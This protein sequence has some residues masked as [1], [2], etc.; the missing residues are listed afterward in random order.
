MGQK[1]RLQILVAD[2]DDATRAMIGATL[3]RNGYDV[4][5]ARDGS[6]ALQS[7]RSES[8][9][10]VVLDLMM[11]VVS[12]WDVLVVRA[13]DA[14]LRRIPVIVAS[15]NR[16]PELLDALKYGVMALLPKPFELDVLHALVS[17]CLVAATDQIAPR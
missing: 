7:M 12:G 1:W 13:G 14:A 4:L 5:E 2:D 8:P 10:L 16:S 6:E 11:P 15:A 3:R 17:S 9:D